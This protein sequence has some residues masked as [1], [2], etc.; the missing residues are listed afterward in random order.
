M[1]NVIALLATQLRPLSELAGFAS[2][3]KSRERGLYLV[4]NFFFRRFFFRLRSMSGPTFKIVSSLACCG[5]I[6]RIRARTLAGRP[7][8]PFALTLV[9]MRRYTS[10]VRR[11]C[12]RLLFRHMSRQVYSADHIGT[13]KPL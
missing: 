8:F 10:R 1:S 5:L 3:A 12:N 2:S 7:V 6:R 11:G 4:L 13:G 9:I